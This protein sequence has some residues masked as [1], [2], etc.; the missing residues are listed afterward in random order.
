MIGELGAQIESGLSSGLT[1]AN[2]NLIVAEERL[3][4]LKYALQNIKSLVSESERDSKIVSK[5][6]VTIIVFTVIYIQ[7]FI[8]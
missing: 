1:R 6:Y 5:Y 4:D 7:Y 3:G 8:P 2:K